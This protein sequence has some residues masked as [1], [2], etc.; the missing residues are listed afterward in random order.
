MT[1]VFRTKNHL[2]EIVQF[3]FIMVGG[4]RESDLL[5]VWSFVHFVNFFSP[6]LVIDIDFFGRKTS[7]T[8]FLG[9]VR[10]LR[11]PQGYIF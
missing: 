10:L 1:L 11:A 8:L 7:P 6:F 3:G 5:H 2:H 4:K 9:G